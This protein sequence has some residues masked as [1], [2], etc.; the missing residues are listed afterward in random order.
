MVT[1]L[2][3]LTDLET[4]IAAGIPAITSQSFLKEE[5]TGAG[6]RHLRGT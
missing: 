6:L 2:R 5:L 1:R 4:L 3:S